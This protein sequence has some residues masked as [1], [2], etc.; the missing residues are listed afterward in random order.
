[1]SEHL[2][3]LQTATPEKGREGATVEGKEKL[4]QPPRKSRPGSCG[5]ARGWVTGPS[6]RCTP[7]QKQDRPQELPARLGPSRSP[8][9]LS[10][11][12][13]KEALSRS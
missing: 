13:L 1:M 5:S 8:G 11:T 7:P 2:W 9:H 3:T 4:K 6:G 12:G 10:P